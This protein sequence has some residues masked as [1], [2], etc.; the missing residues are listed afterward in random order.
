MVLDGIGWYCRSP[1]LQVKGRGAVVNIYNHP[2]LHT[3][4]GTA[5]NGQVQYSFEI[6]WAMKVILGI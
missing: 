4:T 6:V 5:E 1:L 2:A 3:I